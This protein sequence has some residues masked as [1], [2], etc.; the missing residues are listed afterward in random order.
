MEA[1][2]W[3]R[4][5]LRW[6]SGILA[7]VT[8]AWLGGLAL[9]ERWSPAPQAVSVG[10]RSP[11]VVS[12]SGTAAIGGLRDG[13]VIKKPRGPTR[14]PSNSATWTVGRVIGAATPVVTFIGAMA[15]LLFSFRM[16]RRAARAEL[17]AEKELELKIIEARA[18][19]R[20]G[21]RHGREHTG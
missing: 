5:R 1:A 6:T 3:T 17:R 20:S 12:Q 4:K 9:F 10:Y 2:M 21:G 7:S 16:D 11:D 18:K 15:T 19:L 13:S 8:A 14:P